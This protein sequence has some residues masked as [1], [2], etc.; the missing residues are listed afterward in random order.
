MNNSDNT[1]LQRVRALSATAPFVQHLGIEVVDAGRGWCET[2]L[3]LAQHHLQQTGVVHAGVQA[4]LADNTAGAAAATLLDGEEQ[5]IVS[6]EFKINLL[7]PATGEALRCRSEVLKG[8][9]RIIVAQADVLADDGAE[10]RL[11][12]KAIVTLMPV[13]SP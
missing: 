1:V 3:P 11:V 13:V 10:K 4:T 6:V 8:G 5:T 7:R 9:R 12:A 2:R